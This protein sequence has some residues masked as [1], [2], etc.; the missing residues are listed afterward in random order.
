MPGSLLSRYS[1]VPGRSVPVCCVT[2]YCSGES[3]RTASSLL[4]NFRIF[5]SLDMNGMSFEP[6]APGGELRR[7]R[8]GAGC[9]ELEFGT[10]S[11]DAATAIPYE[12]RRLRRGG[13]VW[14]AGMS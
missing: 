13:A 2:R 8:H 5:F 11:W 3:F 9:R 4:V 12:K 7:L 6:I 14:N 10:R 1:P